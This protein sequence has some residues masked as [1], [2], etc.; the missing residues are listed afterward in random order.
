MLTILRIARIEFQRRASRR[1]FLLTLLVPVLIVGGIG[2]IL[3]VTLSSLADAGRGNFAVVDPGGTLSA[4][5]QP[6]GDA[7]FQRLADV[8]AARRALKD[9]TVKA[10]FV[11]TAGPGGTLNAEVQY[12][13]E[14]PSEDVTDAF[15]RFASTA[16]LGD[17]PVTSRL[18]VVEGAT[19]HYATLE[20]G[21]DVDDAGL[22]A[23]FIAPIVLGVLFLVSLLGSAQY[24]LQSV[25]DEKETRVVEVLVTSVTSDQLM[26]GKIIGL[27]AI[28]LTQLLVWIG[29]FLI[30]LRVAASR[31]PALQGVRIAP[32]FLITGLVLFTLELLLFASLLGAIGAI[33]SN[34]KAGSTLSTPIVMLAVLPEFFLPALMIDPQGAI[35]VALSLF[36]FSAPLALLI[37]YASGSVPVWQ[38]LLSIGLLIIAVIAALWLAARI[39][40]YGLLRVGQN[41]RLRDVFQ[42]VRA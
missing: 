22:A 41:L 6:G 13:D 35:S 25:V 18:R 1:A 2:L 29:G 38:V 9:G 5:V 40:R 30:A 28:G 26:A 24:M 11:V 32:E 37:R 19:L 36:P 4:A 20:G 3:T 23:G 31:L 21:R 33:V 10:V 17:L 39:F 12:L 16:R 42:A 15:Q 14:Q 34:A 7:H 27:S 8:D